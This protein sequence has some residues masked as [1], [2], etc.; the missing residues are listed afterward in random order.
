MRSFEVGRI[1]RIGRTCGVLAT[2]L[3]AALTV[4]VVPAQAQTFNVLHSFTGGA[5]GAN[6]AAGL[7]IDR[8]GKLYGTAELGGLSSEYC[9]PTCGTVFRVARSGS[10]WILSTLYQFNGN[11]GAQPAAPVIFG[12]DGTLYGTAG[13]V[14]N[15][16]PRPSICHATT[17][18]W[19]ET[20]LFPFCC[21][22]YS[23][24]GLTFDSQGNLYGPSFDFG[25]INRCSGGLGCGFIYQMTPT[26][27][28]GFWNETDLYKFQSGNDGAH[29]L[30][31]L[32]FD[33][34]GN[35]YGTT[36]G[37]YGGDGFGSVFELTPSGSGW[38]K[39]TLYTFPDQFGEQGSFPF[40]GVIF[41]QA[42][43][44][45]GATTTGGTGGGGTVFEL[46]PSNGGWTYNLLYSFTGTG[47]L[48]GPQAGL[49]MDPDGNLYGTTH[50]D[51]AYGEGSVFKLTHSNGGWTYTSLHDF[52]G[53]ADGS[54]P[55]SGLVL[56]GNGNL[57]GTTFAGGTTGAHCASYENYQCG[58]V[59]EITPN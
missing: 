56:D 43:N 23:G 49:I 35:L 12:A 41:D 47:Y 4:V 22:S 55:E 17:C 48:P 26:S 3:A 9:A 30:G 25:I 36:A 33:R 2:V 21:I 5:D 19:S 58:V 59:F 39:T 6:P 45:Y 24:G 8:G 57:Y 51:G 37:L 10:G 27:G 29:P 50:G 16:R 31:T 13:G 40:A 15:L 32:I 38:T 28:G 44:L 20:V 53:G 18:P 11:D 54:Y 7:A 14:F 34:A 42:G 52:T 1:F 46:T